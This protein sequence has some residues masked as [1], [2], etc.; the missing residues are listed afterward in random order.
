VLRLTFDPQISFWRDAFR[1][2]DRAPLGWF[3]SGDSVGGTHIPQLARLEAD[4]AVAARLPGFI[5]NLGS[6][7]LSARAE[8]RVT[9]IL[10]ELGVT[11]RLA[12]C[13]RAPLV[14]V[15]TRVAF[16]LDS[17]A[18]NLGANPRLT[19]PNA[20]LLYGA[21]FGDFDAALTQLLQ[22]IAAGTYGPPG[23]GLRAAAQAFAD[24]AVDVRG[25]LYRA[26][27]G[28][29]PGD[30]A[31]FLPTGAS[32]GGVAIGANVSR[33]Q[34]ELALT[35]G[36]AGFTDA[37]PLPDA[38]ASALDVE[39][40]MVD[41][42]VGYGAGPLR[43][44]R[45]ALRYWLGDVEVQAR[46][47]VIAGGQY[48]TTLGA[49]VRLPTGHQDSPHNFLD[50]A[51]GDRQLDVE[52]ELTQELTLGG[53]LWLNAALRA[54]LQ[55]P[56]ERERRVGPAAGVLLP[57]GATARL[58]W[59]PG[60]YVAI[61]VAPLYRFT[62]EFGAGLTLGYFIQ[63][64]DRYSY[65]TPQDS[66]AVATALGAPLPAGVLDAGTAERRLV[67]G[68]AVTFATRQ[69]EGAFTVER[70]VSARGVGAPALTQVRIVL[71]TSRRIL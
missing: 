6:A 59:D 13:V 35:W 66:L 21:F 47:R 44:T 37:F 50:V 56:G 30:A 18:G 70:V 69:V 16:A 7:R 23:S 20:E 8:R 43:D 5:A 53:R 19:D 55:R 28:A 11:D 9:P 57:A 54:G 24:S 46:Y 22:N 26:A 71:R 67:V 31:P 42:S 49:L 39:A 68:G 48:A 15:H 62:P 60:D 51:A 64:Q 45:P 61:D 4:V 29:G 65:R 25:A 3:L 10:L 1:N 58:E 52:A 12:I 34:Q 38:R 2:G 27:F 32:A 14:R 17:T 41:R 40:L 36:V 33:I 63:G